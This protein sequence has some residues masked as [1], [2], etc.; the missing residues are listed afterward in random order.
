MIRHVGI[1]GGTF[2]PVHRTHIK[3]ANLA[4]EQYSLDEVWLMPTGDP[5]HKADKQITD[6]S[7]RVKMLN[8]A[9]NEA[10]LNGL[11]VSTFE[12]E[13]VGRI[14]TADTLKLLS[15]KYPDTIWYFILGGDSLLYIEKWYHPEQIFRYAVLLVSV[16]NGAG[17]MELEG[18]RIWLK[19]QYPDARIEFIH[20]E[21]D[22]LSSSQVRTLLVKP[23]RSEQ[24]EFDLKAAIYENELQYI[25]EKGLYVK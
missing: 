11:S 7:N 18:K 4:K 2:D 24:E 20:M 19:E 6:A 10:N 25:K 13:R 1:L 15:E 17:I 21:A 22:S 14:Y 9:L 8:L 12:L 23:Q 16:R 3:L 5:P